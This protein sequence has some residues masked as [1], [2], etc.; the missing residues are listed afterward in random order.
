M[1]VELYNLHQIKDNFIV[2]QSYIDLFKCTFVVY[3]S[4]AEW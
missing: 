4:S 1:G 3:T 2:F